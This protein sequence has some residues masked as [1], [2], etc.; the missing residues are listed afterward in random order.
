MIAPSSRVP[1]IELKLGL[2]ALAEH[3]FDPI[4]HPQVKKTH[5][6]WAGT[7]EERARALFDFA[8]DPRFSVL[9][10]CRGGY[11]AARLVPLLKKLTQQHGK[12]P[13]KLMVGYSDTSALVGYLRE[14]WGWATLHAP[15]PGIRRFALQTP[16]EWASL[17]SL[18]RTGKL[19][20]NAPFEKVKLTFVGPA[21]R[22]EIRAPLVGGNLCVL[23]SLLGTP[24]APDYRGHILFLEDV[25]EPLYRLDRMFQQLVLSGGLKGVK[26]VVLGNF[27]NCQDAVGKV[28]GRSPG[29]RLERIR[30]LSKPRPEEL[31]PI[32]PTLKT[33]SALHQIFS[34]PCRK[35]EIPLAFGVPA[36]H[37]PELGALPLGGRYSLTPQGQLKLLSWNWTGN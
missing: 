12:P 23:V 34:G 17:C 29:S 16:A 18:I 13:R 20:R 11:G 28:L 14:K 3:G 27:L 35:L 31:I 15:M 1:K 33:P 10:S 2:D 22:K 9:W 30:M 32:R 26:A 7:D 37:G 5:L 6:F 4:V 24:D 8:H 36:G 21:P 25:D 19:A